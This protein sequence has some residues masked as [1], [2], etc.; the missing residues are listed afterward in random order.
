[1]S[2]DR[3][4]ITGT[5]NLPVGV[6]NLTNS[7]L[8][9]SPQCTM[10]SG[11]IRA[12]FVGCTFS[13][14]EDIVNNSGNSSNLIVNSNGSQSAT[15]PTTSW[16]TTVNN[17][18]L[19][20]QPANTTLFVATNYGAVGNGTIDDTAA[21]QSAL[22]A[23]GA[24]GG[25]I[26]YLPPGR[27]HTTTSLTVP[28]GVELRGTY[29]LHPGTPQGNDYMPGAV[30]EPVG[31]Q[32][33]TSGPPVIILT[34]NA[35]VVGVWVEYETQYGADSSSI[36]PFPPVIQ[37]QGPND[38]AIGT[39]CANSFYYVDFDTYSCPNHLCYSVDGW[40]L[41]KTFQIGNGSSG[42]IADCSETWTF[43][44]GMYGSASNLGS[45]ISQTPVL[46]YSS[47]SLTSNTF[48][49][50]TETYFDN[51]DEQEN[52]CATFNS[53]N[54]VGP[55]VTM[56]DV[57]CDGTSN[58]AFNFASTA[59]TTVNTVNNS[60][61]ANTSVTSQPGFNGNV[62]LFNT[63]WWAVPDT[64]QNPPYNYDLNIGGGDIWLELFHA[65]QY[66]GD[67][68]YITGGVVHMVNGQFDSKPDGTTPP[69]NIAFG[70]GAGISGDTSEIIGLFGDDGIVF[71][72]SNDSPNSGTLPPLNY[73]DDYSLTSYTV[74]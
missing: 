25:G 59:P 74:L 30:L 27:Y 44:V 22:N 43:W 15:V 61:S 47:A 20:R 4:N 57:L 41:N 31:G 72:D 13:P 40:A 3:C 68:S 14:S 70:S 35:G 1:M 32:G 16:S 51:F 49:N 34:T 29:E 65:A 10:G 9:G 45:G 67:G 17:N 21:I 5:L 48:G 52:T 64:N 36:V 60:L 63:C 56:I 62:Q 37:G 53:E 33:G 18:Y 39:Q 38:Y 55:N 50:C 58:T 24:N 71:N 46:T 8:S 69:Y 12:A 2:F 42:V 73:W 23:A 6:F 11:A 26:V 54:G 7:S 28:E 66:S 19:S